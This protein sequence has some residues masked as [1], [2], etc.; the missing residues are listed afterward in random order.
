M[1]NLALGGVLTSAAHFINNVVTLSVLAQYPAHLIDGHSRLPDA[2]R[3]EMCDRLGVADWSFGGGLQGSRA[4]VA[5]SRRAMKSALAPLGKLEFVS[6]GKVA[7]AAKLLSLAE[8]PA[9]R[10]IAAT[11][12][13]AMTGRSLEM[14]AA[15]PHIHAVLQ[16]QPSDFF[17]RHAYFK[18]RQPKP[19]RADPDRDRCGLSWFAPVV[20]MT[21]DHV[22]RVL[23]LTAPLFAQYGFDHYAALLIQNPRAMIVLMSIFFDFQ[24]PDQVRNARELYDALSRATTAAGYQPYRVGTQ[25]MEKLAAAAP[26]FNAFLSRLKH[27]VDPANVL[28]PG[29]YGVN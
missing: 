2:M 8:R 15:A 28:A 22:K 10:G 4:H 16:G 18:S 23:D 1:R 3:K 24:N 9:L 17:V 20:P 7:L 14:I 26:E 6:D 29:K 21:G 5:A 11:V 25:G 12:A 19:D 13:K 27:A